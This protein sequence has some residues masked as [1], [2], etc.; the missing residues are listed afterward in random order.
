MRLLITRSPQPGIDPGGTF[1]L[2]MD[3]VHGQ[4]VF[5]NGEV[6][7]NRRQLQLP[8]ITCEILERNRSPSEDSASSI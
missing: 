3:D 6:T 8:R 4:F 1:E 7:M 2:P 5:D